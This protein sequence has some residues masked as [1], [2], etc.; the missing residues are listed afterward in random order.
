MVTEWAGRTV[1]LHDLRKLHKAV[2]AIIPRRTV[3]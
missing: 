2:A 1:T 3:S